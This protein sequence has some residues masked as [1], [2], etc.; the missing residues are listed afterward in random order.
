MRLRRAIVSLAF[1]AWP[2]AAQQAEPP[3]PMLDVHLHIFVSGAFGSPAPTFCPGAA[4]GLIPAVDSRNKVAAAEATVCS[5]S[6]SA[7]ETDEDLREKTL[8]ILKEY[9]IMAVATLAPASAKEWQSAEPKRLIPALFFAADQK[10]D[11]NLLQEARANGDLAVLGLAV[12]PNEGYSPADPE[13]ERYLAMAEELDIPVGIQMGPE[14]PGATQF[15]ATPKY[16][17]QYGNALVL[18]NALARHPRLRVYVMHA[19][20]PYS[21]GMIALLH[22]YP[23]VY[24]DVSQIDWYLPREE[25]HKYLWRLVQAGFGK[26]IMFGSDEMIWPDAIKVAIERVASAEFLSAK[27]KRDIFYNNAAKFLRFDPQRMTVR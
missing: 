3:L 18:G 22:A 11:R 14:P 5:I 20:W 27:Q 15:F 23:Q 7:P 19:G 9:N 13:W 1:A 12:T 21:E 25:F 24:V 8:T 6:L 2:V 26:R 17:E 4:D 10:F 16:R